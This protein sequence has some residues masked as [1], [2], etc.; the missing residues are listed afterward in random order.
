MSA[1]PYWMQQRMGTLP[2]IA[3]P[4]N[5]PNGYGGGGGDWFSRMNQNPLFQVGLGMLGASSQGLG[6]G[7]ALNAGFSQANQAMQNA[8]ENS[9]RQ[10][11]MERQGQLFDMQQ[12]EF[13]RTERQADRAERGQRAIVAGRL[14][15]GLGANARDMPQYW[16]LVAGMPEVQ[17][18]VQDLGIEVPS[19]LDPQ[20]WQGIQQQLQA[21]GQVGNPLTDPTRGQ[22]ADIANWQFYQNLSPEQQKQWMS[23]QRQPTAP[24]VVEM[25]GRRWLVDRI[26]GT[27]TPLNTLESE[28]AAQQ[29]ISQG[30]ATGQAT[31]A[32]AGETEKRGVTAGRTL[33]MLDLADPL[34]DA[35]T[36]SVTGAVA[37]KLVGAFGFAPSGAQA[38]AELKVLQASLMTSMPRMEGPQSDADVKLYREAAGQIG[39]P[40]IPRDI[41]KAALQTIRRL[42]RQYQSQAGKGPTGG[43]A[44]PAALE[45]LRANPQFK[46]QF[47][48]KYGYVPEGM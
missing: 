35:A 32:V 16:Q 45:Y 24:Q 15:Q 36:G 22:T 8:Y 30:K 10:Q 23:L 7:S 39:D 12:R 2:G 28:V 6:F 17:Q 4:T 18:T 14:A 13:E 9:L 43:Q 27:A 21:A 3:G 41:K 19:T 11:Q 37:D 48:A 29:A 5:V 47:R 34:I 40:M 46:E 31:G 26:Q 42:Q 1:S 44:P 33:E 38:I 25:G 20:S